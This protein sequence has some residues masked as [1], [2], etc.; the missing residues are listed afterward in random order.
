MYLHCTHFIFLL[1]ISDIIDSKSFYCRKIAHIPDDHEDHDS[2]GSDN[3]SEISSV[4]SYAPDEFR[5]ITAL[6]NKI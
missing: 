4:P 3:P 2:S 6:K 5:C 1:F